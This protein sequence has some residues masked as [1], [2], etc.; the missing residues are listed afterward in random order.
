MRSKWA[1]LSMALVVALGVI[2]TGGTAGAGAASAP[3][4]IVLIT[5][6]TGVAA[7]EY[8][9]APA[10]FLA[11]IALQNASGG[12]NGH[13]I[14][15]LVIDD[16][17]SL[18]SVVTATQDAISKNALGIVAVSPVFFAAAK[19]PQQA[20]VP[21]TGSFSD[22]PEWGEQPYTNM[23][24]SDNG[25]VDPK[26]PAN[27]GTADFMRQHGGTV[28][29]SYGYRI[30]PS[31]TRAA[32]GTADAFRH[33]GGKV[34][35]LDTS[36]PFGSVAFTT[37]ALAAKQA[38][39]NAVTADLDN[40]SN[41]ALATSLQQAGVRPKVVVFPTG[42]EPSVIKSTVW[43]AIQGDYFVTEFRPFSI[44]D[45]GTEQMASALEKYQ[46][47]TRSQF[48]TFG[49]YESWLGATLMIEGIQKAGKNP[50]HASVMKALRGIKDYTGGGILPYQIDYAT[51]FGHDLP[52][53][54]AWYMK[55]EPNGFVAT[56]SQPLCG[57]DIPG[58]ATAP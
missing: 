55:A 8:S 47:F 5:S 57:A 12:I 56:S 17:T 11:R 13:K 45:P 7:A 43:G 16:Q 54:C 18:S 53:E 34:G 4:T 3:I 19:F 46:H 21:V 23:F 2:L 1:T 26:Y 31:S 15:P 10:G 39:V 33:V 49:Q 14:V 22:G 36:I 28:L 44:P 52:K 25:S 6:R 9:T 41:F 37:E 38:R 51:I 42:Y 27:S 48:P 50:T 58:T 40:N 30:S 20:G 24:A 29:G 32:D 35:V